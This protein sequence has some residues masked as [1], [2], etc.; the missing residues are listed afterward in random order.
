MTWPKS[1]VGSYLTLV[2]SSTR[3]PRWTHRGW[4]EHYSIIYL[5]SE[6]RYRPTHRHTN[7]LSLGFHISLMRQYIQMLV[8]SDPTDVNLNRHKRGYHVGAPNLR[9]RPLSTFPSNIFHFPL[10]APPDFILNHYINY[11]SSQRSNL[12]PG[13]KSPKSREWNLPLDF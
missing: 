6:V 1:R 12:E 9:S 7:L 10:I 11:S 4:P 13:Y 5:W 8:H 3:M 2:P